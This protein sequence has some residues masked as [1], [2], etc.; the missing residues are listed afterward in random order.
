MNILTALET[1]M[2]CITFGPKRP[3]RKS[4]DSQAPTVLT[5]RIK[6]V[7]RVVAAVM[8]RFSGMIIIR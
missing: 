7:D 5:Q 4:E 1:F 6:G 2:L 8:K 3:S